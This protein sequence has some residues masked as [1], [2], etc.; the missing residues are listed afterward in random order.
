MCAREQKEEAAV[1]NSLSLLFLFLVLSLP[2]QQ[3]KT[4]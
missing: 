3:K 2:A 1:A 4:A